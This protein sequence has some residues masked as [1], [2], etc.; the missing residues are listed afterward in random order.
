MDVKLRSDSLAYLFLKTAHK[1]KHVLPLTHLNITNWHAESWKPM[2][3]SIT[4]DS[5]SQAFIYPCDNMHAMLM[6]NSW[7]L[8]RFLLT[9]PFPLRNRALCVTC[10]MGSVLGFDTQMD[11]V[12]GC[13][14]I[15]NFLGSLM[16]LQIHP[17]INQAQMAK[18]LEN[19]LTLKSHS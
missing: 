19:T 6:F 1:W 12:D 14:V 5:S 11:Q 13:V 4:R 16:W 8:I 15:G 18:S 9:Q 2:L 17:T 10:N 7:A 3:W